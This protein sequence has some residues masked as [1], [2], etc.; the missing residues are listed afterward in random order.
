MLMKDR[1]KVIFL[2]GASNSGKTTIAKELQDLLV[3]PYLHIGVDTFINMVP[4]RY[5][6]TSD[7]AKQ[8]FYW[9]VGRDTTGVES[10]K[11]CAGSYGKR[12]ITGM[13]YACLALLAKGL[14]IIMDEVCYGK[15]QVDFYKNLFRDYPAIYVGVH[16]PLEVILKRERAGNLVSRTEATKLPR[17]STAAQELAV[18]HQGVTYDLNVNTAV[19]TSL[20]CA[21]EIE[22]MLKRTH[23]QHLSW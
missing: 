8:G 7:T 17:L 19:M 6:G 10:G 23:T 11:I 2:N 9:Q 4:S 13:G 3:E 22:K 1:A 21:E 15:P 18:V 20:E 14:N 5:I 12:V 16:C